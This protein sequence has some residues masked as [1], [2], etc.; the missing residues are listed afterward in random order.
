MAMPAL[1]TTWSMVLEGDI[2]AAVRKRLTWSFQFV[3]SQCTNFTLK[4][5]SE[6]CIIVN[7]LDG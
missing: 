6:M 7:V 4:M 2:E 5:Q 3:T 1:A